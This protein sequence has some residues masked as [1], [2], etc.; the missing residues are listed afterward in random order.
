MSNRPLVTAVIPAYNA[1][2]FLGE[3]IQ[4]VLD[5]TYSPIQIL[6]IDDGSTDHT[7]KVA[8]SFQEVEYYAKPNGGVSSAR[9]FAVPH[10]R[11]E[12]IAFLDADD[13]W[14][15]QKTELQVTRMLRHPGLAL[16]YTGLYVTDERLRIRHRIDPAPSEIALRKTLLVEKPFMTGIGSSGMVPRWIIENRRPLFD[17]RFRASQD[18][19]FAC[20]VALEHPVDGIAEP[21]FLYRQRKSGQVHHNQPQIEHDIKLF[22][23]ELDP[24]KLKK[25]GISMNRLLANLNLSLGIGY[26]RRRRWLRG[27]RYLL[28]GVV[29]RPDR[30]P[31]IVVAR[32]REKRQR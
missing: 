26:L 3:A 31:A 16:L 15:P 2:P 29:R 11:G 13:V 5:Q 27:L 4:S 8:T 30:L 24:Q 6:V 18:R 17:E 14:L 9:N 12:F 28:A 32:V 20:S 10:A 25:S 1:A 19:L 21:L 23:R 7:G 22:V